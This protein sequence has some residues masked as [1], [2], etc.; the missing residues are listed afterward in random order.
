MRRQ[1][2]LNACWAAYPT[3]VVQADSGPVRLAEAVG[4]LSLATDLASGQPLEHGLRRAL[5]ALHLGEASGLSEAELNTVYY[6]ALL[7]GLG[8][9]VNTAFMAPYVHDE[10]QVRGE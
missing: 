4:T 8:C 3:D 6:V 5:I 7:G 10:I 1:V 9:V 2:C